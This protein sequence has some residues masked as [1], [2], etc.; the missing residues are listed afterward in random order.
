MSDTTINQPH[1]L[2]VDVPGTSLLQ[3]QLPSSEISQKPSPTH[4]RSTKYR[5]SLNLHFS[6]SL[7]PHPTATNHLWKW[8][9]LLACNNREWQSTWKVI[10]VTIPLIKGWSCYAVVGHGGLLLEFDTEV[11]PPRNVVWAGTPKN[12]SHKFFM[13][14]SVYCKLVSHHR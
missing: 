6:Y 12:W 8:P 4:N 14:N 1:G 11:T 3:G 9:R 7:L 5:I 2:W 13:W 10:W